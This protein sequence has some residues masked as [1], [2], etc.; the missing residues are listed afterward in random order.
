MSPTVSQISAQR[1]ETSD[2][3]WNLCM[4]LFAKIGK[5]KF[6]KL[7]LSALLFA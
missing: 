3:L 7:D 4:E 5:L 6:K 1:Y 2:G